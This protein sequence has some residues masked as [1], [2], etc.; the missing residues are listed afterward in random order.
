MAELIN[1]PLHDK[2][3][4]LN[5]SFSEF[6]GW[7][8][9]LQYG[10]IVE[11]HNA[12]RSGVGL[13]D[14]SH[15]G[16][17]VA[18]GTGAASFVNECL[19]N[20]L[21]RISP[22]S[23]QYT[24]CCDPDGGV[25][26]DMICYLISDEEVFCVPNAANAAEVAARLK[27][28]A[29]NGVEI[30]DLHTEYA[31][32][33]VQ[34]PSSPAVLAAL[35]LPTELNYMQFTDTEVAGRSVRV[36]RTGYTGELGY[37]LVVAATDAGAVWDALMRA[38]EPYG[39]TPAGLG[40]RD[41]LRTE[42]GYALHGH[43]LSSTITPVQAGTAWAVGWGKESFWGDE[44]LRAEREAG[45]TRRLRALLSTGR[46]IP[47][48]GMAVKDSDGQPAGQVTSGTFSPTLRKG[49]ALALLSPNIAVGDTVTIDVRGRTSDFEVVKAPFVTPR[50]R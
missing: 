23:A 27:V 3:V 19:T 32:L 17:V 44:P 28:A 50:V 31:I 20:D 29:P 33:A 26:D 47:R 12:V 13:F 49:I 8:M 36:C 35:S 43:E 37:E 40:A 4:A 11:E 16:K 21:E 7:N 34:G 25:V 24:L 15:L 22:G 42:M 30:R 1:S 14:V 6:G 18:L 39:I 46:A 45:P 5:A 41:T 10:S 2:H 38:G 9:P 48:D